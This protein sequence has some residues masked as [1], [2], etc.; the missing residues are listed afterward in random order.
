MSRVLVVQSHLI[1]KLSMGE[2]CNIAYS[3][4]SF[5][6]R[7]ESKTGCSLQNHTTIA[8]FLAKDTFLVLR[9]FAWHFA[10]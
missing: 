6:F 4:G 1:D 7:L 9:N 5:V 10:R 3:N 2:Q 8:S